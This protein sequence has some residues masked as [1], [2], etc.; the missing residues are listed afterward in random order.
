MSLAVRTDQQYRPPGKH[1]K[2]IWLLLDTENQLVYMFH[3]QRPETVPDELRHTVSAE[4]GLAVTEDLR[5]W[6]NWGTILKP[7]K[8]DSIDAKVLDDFTLATGSTIKVKDGTYATFYTQRPFDHPTENYISLATSHDLVHWRKHPGNPILSADLKRFDM[9]PET[10]RLGLP[11]AFRDP[12]VF[13]DPQNGETYMTFSSRQIKNM[14]PGEAMEKDAGDK[15]Y[16]ACIGIAKR[17]GDIT[18]WELMEPL[19]SPERYAEMEV[20]QMLYREGIWYA[21]FSSKRNG[22]K[23]PHKKTGLYCYMSKDGLFGEYNPV[24]ENGLI[25]DNKVLLDQFGYDIY[26]IRLLDGGNTGNKYPA[27]GWIHTDRHGNDVKRVSPP[28]TIEIKGDSVKML[29]L[30]TPPYFE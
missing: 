3:M 5:N 19:I 27:L 15:V 22:N 6:K 25:V 24:G 9:G 20:S 26:G 29:D 12:F 18:E 2:D 21:F 23:H 28:F 13:T 17:I 1:L 4:I 11:H 8:P 30:Y 14:R 7:S 16:N 10:D